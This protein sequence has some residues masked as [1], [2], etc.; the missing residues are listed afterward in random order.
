MNNFNPLDYSVC[1]SYPLRVAP[2]AWMEHVPFGMFLVAAL[3]P[4]VV[5]ELGTHYGVSYC[6]FCQV[7]KELDMNTRCFAIDTWQGDAQ[8]GFYGSEVL[9]DLRAHHDP[10]YGSFSSLIQCTFDEALAHFE[11]RSVDLLH[12]DGFHTYEAVK[13]DFE[14]WLPKVSNQGVVLFHDTNARERDFG[15]WKFWEDLKPKYPHLEFIHGHGL[16]LLAVGQEYPEPLQKI[17]MLSAEDL[18]C[19]REFFY[20]FGARL[21]VAQE[22]QS[23]KQE[24][25]RLTQISEERANFIKEQAEVIQDLQERLDQ[26]LI[27]L[28]QRGIFKLQRKRPLQPQIY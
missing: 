26:G 28:V 5:V 18:A 24:L 13:Q 20:Q 11:E 8:A 15:V 22:V 16:G 23:L 12:I 6:A 9:K 3:R 25:K 21:E 17:L 19:I 27:G 4:K 7:V 14:N 10:L 2:S 1:L